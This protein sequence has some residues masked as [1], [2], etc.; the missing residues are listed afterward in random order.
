MHNLSAVFSSLAFPLFPGRLT[1]NRGLSSRTALFADVLRDLLLVC[2][3]D[4]DSSITPNAHERNQII[5]AATP[6]MDR[7]P[8]PGAQEYNSRPAPR[9]PTPRRR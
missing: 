3:S 8:S 2:H 5:R 6:L 1:P 9:H 7:C 4:K